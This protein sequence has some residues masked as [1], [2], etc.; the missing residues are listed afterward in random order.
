MSTDNNKIVIKIRPIESRIINGILDF[1]LIISISDDKS[2]DYYNCEISYNRFYLSEI[3]IVY[4]FNMEY[5]YL[6]IRTE[7]NN[8]R[9]FSLSQEQSGGL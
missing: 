2:L 9:A 8:I 5:N 3:W 1:I 7:K 6:I 4:L